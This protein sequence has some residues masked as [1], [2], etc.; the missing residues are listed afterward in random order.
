[1]PYTPTNLVPASVSGATSGAAIS[2]AA[3][4][5]TLPAAASS[6]ILEFTV[7]KGAFTAVGTL[8]AFK[9]C[10]LAATGTTLGALFA[11][12]VNHNFFHSQS[13]SFKNF[14]KQASQFAGTYLA[15]SNGAAYLGGAALAGAPAVSLGLTCA[16]GAA[17]L[18]PFIR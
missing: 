4:L 18:L 8:G 10:V 13:D 16:I 14:V 7:V 11:N 15:V 1:M 9:V 12:K 2:L 6:K 5:A 3:T 17:V